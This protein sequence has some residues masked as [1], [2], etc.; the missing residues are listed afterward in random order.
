MHIFRCKVEKNVFKKIQKTE[1]K[2]YSFF[3]VKEII[4]D[5]GTKANPNRESRVVV[6]CRQLR[7]FIDFI[8]V[9]RQLS[10]EQGLLNR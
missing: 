3:E 1:D 8:L 10:P 4:V 7:E 5:V 2:I 6:Y 9:K